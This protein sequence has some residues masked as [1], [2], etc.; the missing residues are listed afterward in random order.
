MP[1]FGVIAGSG[2][3]AIPELE[4]IDSVKVSSPYGEPS[5]HY[6]IGRLSGREIVFLPRHGSLHHIPPHRINYRAN[7]WGFRELGVKRILSVGASGGISREMKPGSL[8]V[9]DQIIDRTS[10]REATFYDENDVVHI[11][12]T[13]PFCPDLRKTLLASASQAG[14]HVLGKGTYVAVNGPRLETAAEIRE[15]SLIGADVVG[16]TGMPEA[17]L[18]RELELCFASVAVVTNVAAGIAEAR[19]TTT[20][21]VDVMKA[22]TEHIKALIKTLF[23]LNPGE[24]DCSCSSS[25]KNAR[26][27]A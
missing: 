5:D 2:I 13:E 4:I 17:V 3:Y 11:D 12:F 21:V 9:L 8:V 25:L 20:E 24:P 26:M 15:F 6:R 16:M 7:I 19:L 14:I 22:S 10:G 1:E 27:R 23:S 18:A